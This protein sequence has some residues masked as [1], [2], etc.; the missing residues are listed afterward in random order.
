VLAEHAAA[1]A[2]DEEAEARAAARYVRSLSL[3]KAREYDVLHDSATFRLR[4][5]LLRMP[6][7]GGAARALTR[8]AAG[9]RRA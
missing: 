3:S 7:V 5:R 1:P 8:I 9:T 4:D 6:L 2:R